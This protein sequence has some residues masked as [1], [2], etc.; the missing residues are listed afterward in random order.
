[1]L[2]GSTPSGALDAD[3]NLVKL[4]ADRSLAISTLDD[5]IK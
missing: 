3:F 1:N 5:R 2:R 4:G